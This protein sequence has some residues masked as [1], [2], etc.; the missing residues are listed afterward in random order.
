METSDTELNLHGLLYVFWVVQSR[1]E[2]WKKTL[3]QPI[4]NFIDH[5]YVTNHIKLNAT[6]KTDPDLIYQAFGC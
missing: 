3:S 1:F 4:M 5:V 2:G 6:S